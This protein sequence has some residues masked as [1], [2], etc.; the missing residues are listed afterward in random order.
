MPK[1]L[2]TRRS[3]WRRMDGRRPLVSIGLP[4]FNGEAYLE[5]AIRSVLGQSLD[6]LELVI[7]DN[8]STDQT[9]EICRDWAATDR[10]VRCVRNATN[11]GAAP[12][13]NRTFT[14][15]RGRYFK[16]LAHDDRLRPG[17]LAATVPV[18]EADPGVVLCNTTVDYIDEH[19][20]VIGRYRSPLGLAAAGLPSER[21]AALVLR[22]HSCVDFFGTIRRSALEGSLLHGSFHGADRALLAQLALRGR[23]VQL[24]PALVEMREHPHRYTRL[25]RSGAE[26]HAWH[27]AGSTRRP[28]PSLE[29]HRTYRRLVASEPLPEA[30]RRACRRVLARWWL[31]NWNALRVT[32]DL[33][34]TLAPG[35][36]GWTERAKTRLFGAAP[37]HFVGLTARP[38]APPSRPVTAR[39]AR[40]QGLGARFADCAPIFVVG[41]PRSGTSLLARMLDAHPAIGLADELCFFDIVLGARSQVP[42]LDRPERIEHFLELLPR[43]DHVRYWA[44]GEAL[45]AAAAERLRADPAPSYARFYRHLMEARAAAVGARRFGEK[46]PWN[47]RHLDALEALFPDA[48]FVHIVRDP[49]AVV[50]SKRK[51][52]RTS[53]DVLTNAVK[54]SIDVAAAGRYLDG[55]SERA[56]RLLEIRYEDLIRTPER[57][58]RGVCD[59]LGEPFDAAMLA[60]A[61]LGAPAFRDQP[62]REGVL[63]PLF[64]SSLEAWRRDL[65]PAQ[66]WLVQRLTRA[67]MAR[68]G[69]PAEPVPL[70]ALAGLP[71]QAL[72][73]VL[74]WLRFKREETRRLAAEPEIRFRARALPLYQLLLDLLRHR[75]P[76][77]YL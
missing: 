45:I 66:V 12:N 68:Y 35:F 16:W 6:D 59:F 55:S 74:A 39:G 44:D 8:A 61:E 5:E 56:A 72:R 70:R 71:P 63:R 60:Y 43:M 3:K 67:G 38:P 10:R 15:S 64:D 29:L 1:G 65:S 22:S 77:G 28:V 76:D 27:R 7:S 62:Y 57:V 69:Y 18:L 36:V 9:A 24:E 19:G 11:L 51:L 46:T 20:T 48:R 30:E 13:Y 37:G 34:D 49:R 75:G 73:E 54:W 32:A 31:V 41:A 52:P 58:L 26:R 14:E 21:F 17:Y 4:V 25:K 53:T 40:A 47:V 42:E 33:V 2:E 50:A 23:M